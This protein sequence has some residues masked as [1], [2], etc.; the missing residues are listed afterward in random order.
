MG[1]SDYRVRMI[2]CSQ[3]WKRR[4]FYDCPKH[5]SR[6]DALLAAEAMAKGFYTEYGVME[7]DLTA[8][9]YEPFA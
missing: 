1:E 8:G 7:A 4:Y 9:D 5:E 6:K 2:G 3:T